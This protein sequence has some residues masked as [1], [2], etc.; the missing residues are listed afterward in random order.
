MVGKDRHADRQF[1]QTMKYVWQDILITLI[2]V[3]FAMLYA[4]ADYTT[5]T[6]AY[7][8]VWDNFWYIIEAWVYA[9]MAI[10]FNKINTEKKYKLCWKIMATFLSIRAIW[11]VSAVTQGVSVNEKLAMSIL[12]IITFITIFLVTFLPLLKLKWQKQR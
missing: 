5:Y 4:T 9:V 7:P 2:L 6:D 8:N 12:F 3:N 1:N 11:E 10:A